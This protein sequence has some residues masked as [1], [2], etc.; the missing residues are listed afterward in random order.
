[1]DP[2]LDEEGIAAA[3]EKSMNIRCEQ[4]DELLLDGEPLAMTTAERHAETCAACADRLADWNDISATARSMKTTW[5]SDLLLPRILRSVRPKQRLWS[6]AAAAVLTIGIGASTWFMMRDV[7]REAR[8]DQNILRV[9][10]LDDV[11]RAEQA[12]IDAIKRLEK[13]AE[14]VLD[15]ASTP[16]MISYKEK[17][18]LLDDAIAECE[19]QIE[20]NRGNA[21]L[22]KELLAIYTAKQE[23]LSAALRES[24]NASNQ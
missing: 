24:S 23:T 15:K 17:V 8:F 10:A 7:S 3:V 11:E 16:L 1:V 20:Q 19:S 9:A 12:H 2:L 6:V 14:P 22:R 4:F 18:M 5:E 13:V 21:H